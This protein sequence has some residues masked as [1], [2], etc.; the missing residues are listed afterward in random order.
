MSQKKSRMRSHARALA[1]D[2]PW[3]LVGPGSVIHGELL[4]TGN[5]LIHGRVEGVVF[6]DG[7][8]RVA[9]GGQVDGGIHADRIEVEGSCEGRLEATRAVV[10]REGAVVRGD[11]DAGILI[12]DD[13]ARFLGHWIRAGGD[14]GPKTQAFKDTPGHA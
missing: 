9:E 11:I 4:M 7:E 14:Q 5:V 2:V 12:V 1:R 3:T 10:L 8:V 13:G 6:T